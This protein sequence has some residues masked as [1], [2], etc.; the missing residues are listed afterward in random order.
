M[1]V[2]YDKRL[3]FFLLNTETGQGSPLSS[4]LFNTIEEIL[5]REIKRK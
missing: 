5:M 1:A 4:L 3:I 2:A